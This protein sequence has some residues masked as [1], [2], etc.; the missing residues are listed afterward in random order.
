MQPRFGIRSC[1]LDPVVKTISLCNRREH[2]CLSYAKS[3]PIGN[4]RVA[5]E[6]SN[7][8]HECDAKGPLIREIPTKFH[9]FA[10]VRLA[11]GNTAIGGMSGTHR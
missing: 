6:S 1:Q 2:S 7:A 5:E 11:N 3:L 4:D 9:P 10:A 8:A